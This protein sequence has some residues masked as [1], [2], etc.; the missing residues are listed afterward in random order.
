MARELKDTIFAELLGW[1]ADRLPGLASVG[2]KPCGDP[3][4]E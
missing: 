4:E 1:L 2:E 3:F